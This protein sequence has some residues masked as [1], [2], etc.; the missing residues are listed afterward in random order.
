[1]ANQGVPQRAPAARV[2]GHRR[3]LPRPP[4][5]RNPVPRSRTMPNLESAAASSGFYPDSEEGASRTHAREGSTSM[6]TFH[7]PSRL[8]AG[9]DPGDQSPS[10]TAAGSAS[11]AA[12]DVKRKHG[13]AI[14]NPFRKQAASAAQMH[15]PLPPAT[16]TKAA[17]LLGMV[18]E[19]LGVADDE[20][21]GGKLP[22]LTP[23][24]KPPGRFFEDFETDS[25]D[26][27]QPK[28]KGFWAGTKDTAKKMSG[29]LSPFTNRV[30]SFSPRPAPRPFLPLVAHMTAHEMETNFVNRI[31]LVDSDHALPYA[32]DAPTR[33][34]SSEHAH[35]QRFPPR[36]VNMH[37]AQKEMMNRMTPIT[38]ASHDDM[39]AAYLH[40]EDTY[41]LDVI[42]EYANDNVSS[43]SLVNIPQRVQS[44]QAP[45]SRTDNGSMPRFQQSELWNEHE[46]LPSTPARGRKQAPMV[47]RH[48]SPLQTVESQLLDVAEKELVNNK[49][50]KAK[51]EFSPKAGEKSAHGT[52]GE[53][54]TM[55]PLPPAAGDEQPDV[56]EEFLNKAL[57]ECD[58][59]DATRKA[60]D[61]QVAVMRAKHEKDKE[62]FAKL[63][64]RFKAWDAVSSLETTKE[65][66][67][68]EEAPRGSPSDEYYSSDE[69]HVPLRKSIDLSEEPTVHTATAMTFIRVTPGMVKKIDIPPRKKKT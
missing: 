66:T 19:S 60:L 23:D 47:V 20:Q 53:V 43:R 13:L 16:P 15:M 5:S 9:L 3:R 34:E 39:G 29:S 26:E 35:R 28:S 25:D 37:L 14:A 61:A 46:V 56:L 33:P 67:K 22:V 40:G 50:A 57:E 4:A 48:R 38:E 58:K 45:A 7:A 41:E 68:E 49:D 36:T 31:G 69:G 59:R 51:K 1:M 30:Q 6:A 52:P 10:L 65:T 64:A 18:P 24:T 8:P 21:P 42:D 32:P 44:L 27:E 11:S 54:D 12:A 55:K 62:D 63:C 2:A 17:K